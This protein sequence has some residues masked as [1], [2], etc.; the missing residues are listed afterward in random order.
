MTDDEWLKFISDPGN[1]P[2]IKRRALGI[3]ARHKVYDFQA[4][5]GPSYSEISSE[6]ELVSKSLKEI[7]C[8][9][10][11]LKIGRNDMIS[12][13]YAKRIHA[14]KI[15]NTLDLHNF[16][17]LEAIDRLKKFIYESW[18]HDLRLISVITGIG[19]TNIGDGF[20]VIRQ[21]IESW[22]NND[23][24]RG[25]ILYAS[26]AQQHRG[27]QGALLILLRRKNRRL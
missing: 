26:W 25:C 9:R 8:F 2:L 14:M 3:A 4:R 16:R 21:N 10:D 22:L 24:I 5:T 7:G 6:M 18:C 15:E 13:D 23:E 20:G 27:G 12:K 11:N 19:S 17:H 1:Q